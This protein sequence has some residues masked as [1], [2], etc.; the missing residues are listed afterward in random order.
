MTDGAEL[1]GGEGEPVEIEKPFEWS[2][3][4]LPSPAL[5]GAQDALPDALG[6]DEV[7]DDT[8]QGAEAE[9][10]EEVEA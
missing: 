2:R 10:E 8:K 9:A 3:A 1:N 4:S 6:P 5:Y 7:L